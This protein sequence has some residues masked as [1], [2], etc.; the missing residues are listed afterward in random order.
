[1][2]QALGTHFQAIKTHRIKLELQLHFVWV[3]WDLSP[4]VLQ[5]MHQDEKIKHC[6]INTEY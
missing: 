2:L 4:W 5:Y 6:N 3:D 1:M